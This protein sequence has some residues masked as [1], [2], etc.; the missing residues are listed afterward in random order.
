VKNEMLRLRHDDKP[1][2]ELV[3]CGHYFTLISTLIN[4]SR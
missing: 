3:H 1:N 4:Y 2:M